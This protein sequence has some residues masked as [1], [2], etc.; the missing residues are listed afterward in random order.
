M[1]T[2]RVSVPSANQPNADGAATSSIP[3]KLRTLGELRLED[4][5]PAVRSLRRQERLLL[6]YCARHG[7]VRRAELI[8]LLW[9]NRDES[10]AR[11]SLRQ[12]LFSLQRALPGVLDVSAETVRIRPHTIE[13]DLRRLEDDVQQGR[14]TDAL[15]RWRG[16]FLAGLEDAGDE[17]LRAW[18]A[19]ERA[20]LSRRLDGVID[21]LLDQARSTGEWEPAIAAA[22]RWANAN[23]WQER[24]H[25]QLVAALMGAGLL[26]EAATQY[27]RSIAHLRLELELEPS[28]GFAKL[29]RA[30][31]AATQ[32]GTV[33]D[34]HANVHGAAE[35]DAGVLEIWQ[36][37]ANGPG[38]LVFAEV[39]DM[40]SARSTCE[41][42]ATS[43]SLNDPRALVLQ[44]SGDAVSV[45]ESWDL[46]RALLAGLR[47]A[48]GLSGVDDRA[49]AELTRLVP[50]I[51]DRFPRLP[52]PT[53]DE[54]ALH[55]AVLD[56][57]RDVALEVPVLLAVANFGHADA[58][59]SSLLHSLALRLPPRVLLV[60]VGTAN[61]GGESAAMTQL[62]N[63]VRI[64]ARAFVTPVMA[65]P[66][67]LRRPRRALARAAVGAGLFSL[68]V[69]LLSN[70]GAKQTNVVTA[71]APSTAG[72]QRALSLYEEGIK[73]IYQEG[74]AQRGYRLFVAALQAAPTFAMAAFYAGRSAIV[75]APDSAAWYLA[76]AEQLAHTAPDADRLLI[77]AFVFNNYNDPRSLAVAETLA[78]RFPDDPAGA[79]QV[80]IARHAYGD[81]LG[82]VAQY[83]RAI[84]LDPHLRG[85]MSGICHAC[86]AY[87]GMIG[88][89]TLADS[90]DAAVRTAR[91]WT[92]LQPAN[93]DAWALLT[94]VLDYRGS[95][96]NSRAAQQRLAVL[97]NG[98][99][100]ED[101][102][103]VVRLL[104]RG[105]F[106]AADRVLAVLAESMEPAARSAALWWQVVS[107]RYQGLSAEALAAAARFAEVERARGNRAGAL[108]PRAVMLSEAGEPARAMAVYDSIRSLHADQGRASRNAR[109]QAWWLT[110]A[111]S[112]AAAAGDTLRL[113]HLA[114]SVRVIG[115]RSAY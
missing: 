10:S 66:R 58:Q 102:A 95:H 59:T 4:A 98:S 78:V 72:A 101:I 112:A 104:R 46:A 6:A 85:D 75:A 41:R 93:V 27:A 40:A 47:A 14:I 97:R 3:A 51:R 69:L 1:S 105:E 113:K 89:Y 63:C 74:D 65:P 68:F 30:L 62:A 107:Y 15:A 5:G 79:V 114:D 86:E 71:A 94:T 70:T 19:A 80:A 17:P 81:F 77:R 115:A 8:A 28:A 55:R 21:T 43:I 20:G 39:S 31:A 29:G 2:R 109:N 56:T 100:V 9:G 42:I 12:A 32:N 82:A 64:P 24:A 90:L 87:A 38:S 91:A 45:P 22:Q 50:S 99:G 7:V 18:I 61:D 106:I 35:P 52:L 44:A 23:P 16:D 110:H 34:D 13:L 11:H 49:L 48:P 25:A 33:D 37:V 57:L 92:K 108:I 73:A 53:G 103:E 111:G 96:A 83:R 36:A 26:E 67:W 60:L 76:R 84:R 54:D 88:A